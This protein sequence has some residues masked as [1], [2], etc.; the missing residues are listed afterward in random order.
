[1]Q[2]KDQD[3]PSSSSSTLPMKRLLHFFM[4]LGLLD[5]ELDVIHTLVLEEWNTLRG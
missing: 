3:D 1:M 4:I 2:N 5:L